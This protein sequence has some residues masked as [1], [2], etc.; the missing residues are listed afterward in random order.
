MA[1]CGFEPFVEVRWVWVDFVFSMPIKLSSQTNT[2]LID[3]N[4]LKCSMKSLK[5]MWVT[6]IR[7]PQIQQPFSNQAYIHFIHLCHLC[8][9]PTVWCSIIMPLKRW[10]FSSPP[11]AHKA[12]MVRHKELVQ[13]P[14]P[15]GNIRGV[16]VLSNESVG[17][18][19]KPVIHGVSDMGPL[20]KSMGNWGKWPYRFL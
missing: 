4:Y 12:P 5:K 16:F 6:Y 13:E 11:V 1:L 3:V 19:K 20:W 7:A 18:C 2:L 14:V 9:K 15:F 8:T 17:P 10:H